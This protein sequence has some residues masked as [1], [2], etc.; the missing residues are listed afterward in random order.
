MIGA[1]VVARSSNGAGPD[2]VVHLPHRAMRA[3][4]CLQTVAVH[5]PTRS[6][7]VRIGT[8]AACRSTT[9][10][11]DSSHAPVWGDMVVADRT[12][13]AGADDG[14]LYAVDGRTGRARW[15]FDVGGPVRARATV[16]GN[17]LFVQ[18]DAGWLFKLDAGR[19]ME[20]WRVRVMKDPVVRVALDAR[21]CSSPR[22]E[23]PMPAPSSSWTRMV[24]VSIRSRELIEDLVP[25]ASMWS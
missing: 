25:A 2:R 7:R 19:G 18:S 9:I 20:R 16:A 5:E 1:R 14:H 10:A 8:S 24:S 13:F 6:Y 21:S 4:A 23:H 15:T 17:D 12:V 3:A 11:I 22:Y